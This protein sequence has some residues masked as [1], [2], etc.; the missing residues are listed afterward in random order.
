MG[1]DGFLLIIIAL[2]VTIFEVI[3]ATYL[4]KKQHIKPIRLLFMSLPT[5]VIIWVVVITTGL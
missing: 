3:L 1:D 4:I 5:L 2:I